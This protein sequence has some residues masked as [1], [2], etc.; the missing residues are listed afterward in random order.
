MK[1]QPLI[2]IDNE[3]LE[4]LLDGTFKMQ[5]GQWFRLE[6]SDKPSRWVGV[7]EGGSLWASHYPVRT[8]HFRGLC[9]TIYPNPTPKKTTKGEQ[10]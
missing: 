7:T 3:K 9:Q 1:F 4:Q 10:Q 5:R 6:F 2:I 8:E